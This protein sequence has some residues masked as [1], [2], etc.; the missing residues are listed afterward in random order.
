[1]AEPEGSVTEYGARQPDGSTVWYGTDAARA[2]E[3]AT[4][5]SC[6]LVTREAGPWVEIPN[7]LEGDPRESP[8]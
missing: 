2:A 7:P 1:M 4:M 3:A 5:T 8:S 6:K